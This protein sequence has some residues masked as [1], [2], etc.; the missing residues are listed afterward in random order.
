M[1]EIIELPEK[2]VRESVEENRLED[3]ESLITC[4]H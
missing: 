1:I 2:G 4:S 3:V